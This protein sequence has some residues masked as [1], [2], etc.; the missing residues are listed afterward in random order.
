MVPSTIKIAMPKKIN[1][2]GTTLTATILMMKYFVRDEVFHLLPTF[3][4]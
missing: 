4:R 1:F 3:C 2:F